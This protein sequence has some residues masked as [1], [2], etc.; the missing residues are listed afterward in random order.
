MISVCEWAIP[1]PIQWTVID[2][3]VIDSR[4]TVIPTTG[5]MMVL[6]EMTPVEGTSSEER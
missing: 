5:P 1:A 6:A 2:R 4:I 3:T